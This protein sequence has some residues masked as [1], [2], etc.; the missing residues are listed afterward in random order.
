M[1]TL[2]NELRNNLATANELGNVEWAEAL[3]ARIKVEEK[4]AAKQAKEDQA[5][6]EAEAERAGKELGEMTKAELEAEAAARGIEVSGTKA[7]ILAALEG[8][9]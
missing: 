8:G 2:L 1:T 6:A 9:E 5:E 4:A 3:E 7:D